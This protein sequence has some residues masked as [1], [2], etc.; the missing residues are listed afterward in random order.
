MDIM[1]NPFENTFRS[2]PFQ[3]SQDSIN[4]FGCISGE[5]ALIHTDPEYAKKTT[6]GRTI[7]HGMLIL[8]LMLE[9]VANSVSRSFCL[10]NSRLEAR[11]LKPVFADEKIYIVFSKK[12]S[13]SNWEIKCEDSSSNQLVIVKVQL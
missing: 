12:D 3:I 6:F 11:F 7:V 4:S 2:G 8:G 13:E 5:E 1:D 10:S 9:A